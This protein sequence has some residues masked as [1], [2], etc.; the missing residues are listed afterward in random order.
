LQTCTEEK[1]VRVSQ[2][3]VRRLGQAEAYLTVREVLPETS[4]GADGVAWSELGGFGRFRFAT[5]G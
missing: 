1:R 3:W 2:M 4:K 5:L